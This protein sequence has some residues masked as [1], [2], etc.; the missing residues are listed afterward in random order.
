MD[1]YDQIKAERAYQKKR[2]GDELDDKYNTPW[3]WVAYITAYATRW[4]IGSFIPLERPVVEK[5]RDSMIK[6]AAL[7]VAAVESLDRQRAG[8]ERRAF[9]E[10]GDR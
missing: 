5:F 4:M 9:Y 3:M 7:A 1:I 2:W 10:K 6:V 8:A